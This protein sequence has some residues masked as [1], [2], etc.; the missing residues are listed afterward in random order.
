MIMSFY[1]LSLALKDIPLGTG[2]A[3]WTG[4]GAVGTVIIG[5]ILLGE[6]RKI[7]RILC[8]FLIITKIIGIKLLLK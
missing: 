1:L 7:G 8:I 3:I 2:Y 4:I 5:I 6:S